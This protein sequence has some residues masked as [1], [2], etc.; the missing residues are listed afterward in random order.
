[1]AESLAAEGLGWLDVISVAAVQALVWPREMSCSLLA[2][3]VD[4]G[5][6][7]RWCIL[8][9]HIGRNKVAVNSIVQPLFL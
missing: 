5:M 6:A 8:I 7:C 9:P 4:A 2:D 1:M 3:Q